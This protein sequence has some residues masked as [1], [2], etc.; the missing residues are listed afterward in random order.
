M[1]LGLENK[2]KAIAAGA[3][4]LF[5]A[6]YGFH[7]LSGNDAPAP[8]PAV[9]E[10]PGVARRSPM[11]PRSQQKQNTQVNTPSLDPRLKLDLLRASEQI[12]YSGAGRNI[13]AETQE[14]LPRTTTTVI[15]TPPPTPQ[16][17]VAQGPPP[18]NLKFFGFASRPG[19]AKQIFLAD[20]DDVF[21]ARQGDVVDR[22]YKVVEIR[23]T[24][25]VIQDVLNNNTQ[26]IP[27]T[28]S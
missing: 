26:R 18:I 13:F 9:G 19:E 28:A 20:G 14:I 3:L 7:Q 25:V 23:S 6:W 22:R 24:E 11:V 15:R 12:V 10:T 1:K 8:K 27:L 16:Q 4:V 5:A 2:G 17:Q 21:I